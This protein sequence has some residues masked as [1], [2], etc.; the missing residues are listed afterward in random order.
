[1]SIPATSCSPRHFKDAPQQVCLNDQVPNG[2]PALTPAQRK[3]NWM[4]VGSLVAVVVLLLVWV[5]QTHGTLQTIG[6]AVGLLAI[7]F[8]LILA[9]R[10]LREVKGQ[11]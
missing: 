4:I 5:G 2:W 3:R 10:L 6:Q 9:L 7:V 8:L 1:M 11:K